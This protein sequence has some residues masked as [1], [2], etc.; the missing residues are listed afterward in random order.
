MKLLMEEEQ[1]EEMELAQTGLTPI[2]ISKMGLR[3]H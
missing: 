2:G 1:K 3:T